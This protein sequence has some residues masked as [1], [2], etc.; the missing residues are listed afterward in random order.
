MASTHYADAAGL[1]PAT[2]STPG[3]QLQLAQV[4]LTNPVLASIVRQPEMTLPGG[5]VVE[6]YNSLVGHDGVVGVK[7]GSS[8]DAGGSL[9]LA[10]DTTVA[11]R[12]VQILSVV[13]GQPGPSPLGALGTA[14]SAGQRLLDAARSAISLVTV[15]PT[16]RA[17]AYLDRPWG[18]AI[19][20]SAAHPL[21]VL[22]WPGLSVRLQFKAREGHRQRWRSGSEV[23]VL[24]AS[25]GSQHSSV[26][27]RTTS[28]ANGPSLAWRLGRL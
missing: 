28:A 13:L 18:A 4:A 19:P 12:P 11:G 21:S 8:T 2:V 27:V 25:L 26:A 16:T 1:D 9:V 20:A 7:T 23:G 15:R 14:I 6:N 17:A 22:A 3:D 5:Q 10:A 24:G